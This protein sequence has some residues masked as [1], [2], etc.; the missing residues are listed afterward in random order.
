LAGTHF[1]SAEGRRLSWPGEA[2]LA[3]IS[4]YP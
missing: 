4:L 1:P 2:E 3:Y